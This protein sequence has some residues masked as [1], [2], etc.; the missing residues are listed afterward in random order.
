M[1]A[2][3]IALERERL[4]IPR[5]K[6][7]CVIPDYRTNTNTKINC[8]TWKSNITKSK[9]KLVNLPKFR[10]KY[11]IEVDRIKSCSLRRPPPQKKLES[12]LYNI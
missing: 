12:K 6:G 4:K 8:K 7:R 5:I 1:R 9:F 11:F 10:N 3:E 2:D